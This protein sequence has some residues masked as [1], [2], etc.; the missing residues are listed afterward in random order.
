MMLYI[1]LILSL[2]ALTFL[3]VKM[4]SNI[5]T[6]TGQSTQMYM[7]IY[8]QMFYLRSMM[9]LIF[10]VAL[11][12]IGFYITSQINQSN[13]LKE[14]GTAIPFISNEEESDVTSVNKETMDTEVIEPATQILAGNKVKKNGRLFQMV[15]ESK[16]KSNGI[17]FETM[18]HKGVTYALVRKK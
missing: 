1:I 2:L 11:L 8:F 5:F 12:G 4:I 13:I 10:L 16:L 17:K 7:K 3:F 9:T 18:V 14:I 6:V 15:E